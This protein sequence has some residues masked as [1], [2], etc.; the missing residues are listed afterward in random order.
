MKFLKT[1]LLGSV[2]LLAACQTNQPVP[3]DEML[4]P[5]PG[6]IGIYYFR[7][8]VRCE[9]CNAIEEF[10]KKEL[11]GT[12][13]EK[14]KS[15]EI[16]FRQ[17]NLDEPGVADFAL[18]FNVVFKSL[19]IVKNDRHINLTN[20]AFLYALSKPEKLSLLFEETIDK[21]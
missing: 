5:D 10:I 2:F 9:T 12:Y 7:T 1:I 13:S 6:Q 16:V 18:Q 4:L 17:F 20:K 15:G 3:N 19:I 11:A 8:S 14:V 21:N